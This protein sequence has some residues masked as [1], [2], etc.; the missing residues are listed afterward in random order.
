MILYIVRKKT[1]NCFLL[2]K[3]IIKFKIKKNR[4]FLFICDIRMEIKFS[5]I[6]PNSYI[7]YMCT[8]RFFIPRFAGVHTGTDYFPVLLTLI[9]HIPIYK[10]N[11]N[12]SRSL[13]S[14]SLAVSAFSARRQSFS[15]VHP[16]RKVSGSP[17][18]GV[19]AVV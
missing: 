5:V 2:N 12:D 3:K 13:C 6:F 16:I 15:N 4:F 8:L 9:F 18:G 17:K 10:L 7:L 19:H 14:V 11:T 1:L